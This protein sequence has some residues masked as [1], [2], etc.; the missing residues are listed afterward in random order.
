[1]P[2]RLGAPD[3]SRRGWIPVKSAGTAL[4][5][6]N[7]PSFPRKRNRSQLSSRS[8]LMRP[9]LRF[10]VLRVL[11]VPLFLALAGAQGFAA[12]LLVQ[13]SQLALTGQDREHGLLVTL[14]AD[15]GHQEDVTS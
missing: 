3:G 11:I 7:F 9:L 4:R 13:P 8:P 1:M 15:D 2:P 5:I 6:V 12:R 10:H 14:V